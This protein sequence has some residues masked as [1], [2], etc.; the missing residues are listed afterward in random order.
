MRLRSMTH[1][2]IVVWTKR[3]NQNALAHPITG[4][5]ATST[6]AKIRLGIQM[7]DTTGDLTATIGIRYSTDGDSWGTVTQIGSLS[8]VADGSAFEQ[9]FASLPGTQEI[10]CQIVVLAKN[11]SNSALEQAKVSLRIETRDC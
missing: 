4:P 7:E 8:K 6:I 2:P 5:L 10:F 1:G 9:A 3:D 11:T